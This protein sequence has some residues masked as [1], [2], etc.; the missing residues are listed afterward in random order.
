MKNK[1]NTIIFEGSNK[2]DK[3]IDTLVAKLLLNTDD[4][5][6]PKAEI[7][8]QICENRWKSLTKILTLEDAELLQKKLSLFIKN[9]NKF[10][11]DNS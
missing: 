11:S 2:D 8:I 3:E 9:G 7:S 1:N 6:K 10:L 5:A 4:D